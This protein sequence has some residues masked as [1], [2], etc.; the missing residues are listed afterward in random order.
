[1]KVEEFIDL[2]HSRGFE[3][4]YNLLYMPISAKS[5][6]RASTTLKNLGYVFLDFSKLESA[7]A[8]AKDFNDFRFPG[9]LSKKPCTTRPAH[10]QGFEENM[11]MYTSAKSA[12]W[13]G[14]VGE[15]GLIECVLLRVL[16][17]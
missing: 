1:M 7:E 11:Q 10:C 8:F 3:N 16:S 9:R 17:C 15:D 14:T 2:I 13:L 6:G 4:T 5:Q 12:G